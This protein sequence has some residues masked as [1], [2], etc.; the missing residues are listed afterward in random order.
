MS[1]TFFRCSKAGNSEVKGRMWPEFQPVRDFMPVL[2]IC[3]FDDDRIKNEGAL[4]SLQFF[5]IICLWEKNF[6]VQGQVTSDLA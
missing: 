1:T 6:G 2:I 4:V 5:S 3:K